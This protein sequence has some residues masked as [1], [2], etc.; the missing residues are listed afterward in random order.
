MVNNAGVIRDG[1]FVGMK[2]E[3]WDVVIQTIWGTFNFCHA[4]AMN[5]PGSRRADHQYLQ[6]CSHEHEPGPDELRRQ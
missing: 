3:E 5:W 1:L 2:P 6:R 4:V